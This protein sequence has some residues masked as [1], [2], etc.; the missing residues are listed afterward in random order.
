MK[1]IIFKYLSNFLITNNILTPLQSGFAPG[2]ST[3]NQLVYLYNLFCQALD[4]G[5]KIR[6][7]FCDISK[8]S[9]RVW[10]EG[11]LVKLKAVGISDNL[12][13]WFKD[14]LNDRK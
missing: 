13:R 8:A 5:K 10:H 9:D 1:K 7:I 14:Y 2:D 3:T 4:V 6:V 12:L 11:L